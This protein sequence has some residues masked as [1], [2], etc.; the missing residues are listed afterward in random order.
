VSKRINVMLPDRTLA[1]LNRVAPRGGR[2]RFVS[3]AV[4][5]FVATNGRRNLGEQLKLGYQANAEESLK[6]AAEE[7]YRQPL[8]SCPTRDLRGFS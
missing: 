5:H 3:E 7:R 1:V 2:S 4:L 6:I 8:P